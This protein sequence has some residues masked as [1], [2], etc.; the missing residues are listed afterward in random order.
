MKKSEEYEEVAKKRRSCNGIDLLMDVNSQSEG[1]GAAGQVPLGEIA[2]PPQKHQRG[3]SGHRL[4]RRATVDSCSSPP[5]LN[6]LFGH[7]SS[8]LLPIPVT[9]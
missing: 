7:G 1:K 3:I 9:N 5:S 8:S 2:P 4:Q 6:D